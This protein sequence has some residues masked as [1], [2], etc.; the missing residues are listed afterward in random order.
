MYMYESS[1]ILMNQ[2]KKKKRRPNILPK[3][4][5]EL[6]GEMVQL[7]EMILSRFKYAPITLIDV[8]RSFSIYKRF[9]EDKLECH[10]VINHIIK[11][12]V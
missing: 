5:K 3:I 12:I 6:L 1:P 11:I 7:D 8:E 2:V 10:L 4:N 9:T